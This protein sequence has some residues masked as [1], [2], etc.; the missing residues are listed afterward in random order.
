MKRVE[1]TMIGKES[2][3]FKSKGSARGAMPEEQEE[4]VLCV[5]MHTGEAAHC[6]LCCLY[7]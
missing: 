5:F 3:K 7:T 1:I 2:L 6:A 4:E